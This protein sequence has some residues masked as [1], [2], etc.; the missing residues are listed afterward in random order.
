MAAAG[1]MIDEEDK[2]MIFRGQV[3]IAA[4]LATKAAIVSGCALV[5]RILR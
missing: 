5:S 3:N 1:G 4:S 2:I